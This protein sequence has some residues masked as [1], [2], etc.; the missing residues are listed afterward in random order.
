[1]NCFSYRNVHFRWQGRPFRRPM[2]EAQMSDVHTYSSDVAFSPA[3]KAIQARKGSRRGYAQ[4]EES[5]G[6]RAEVDDNLAAFLGEANSLYFATASADG[7]PYIQHRGG[8]K[9]F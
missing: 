7:Q 9:G 6:W 5:G 2:T 1:M 3:V 4:V 8:P